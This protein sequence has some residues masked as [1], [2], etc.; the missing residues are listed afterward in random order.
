MNAAPKLTPTTFAGFYAL[1]FTRLVPVV[2]YNATIREKSSL[3]LRV[4]TDQDSRGK[5]VGVRGS[6]GKW[7]GWDWIPHESDEHDCA[8][9]EKMGA[10]IGIKTGQ[11]LVAIDADTL[12][13]EYAALIQMTVVKH[14]SMTPARIGNFPKAL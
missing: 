4:G 6:D 7:F 3:A 11:G 12:N 1:G 2:P 14:F 8:R 13:L 9:W 5:A 10:G